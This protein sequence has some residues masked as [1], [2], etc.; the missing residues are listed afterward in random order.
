M[1]ATKQDPRTV[2][3]RAAAA[4]RERSPAT[5]DQWFGGIQFD[6]LTDGVLTLRAQNEFVMEWVKTNFVPE[7]TQQIERIAGWSIQ[8]NWVLDGN[9][10]DPVTQ[11]APTPPPVKPRP[12]TSGSSPQ[13]SDSP[14]M[15]GPTS[16][17]RPNS[18]PDDINP[19]H[20]F[21]NFV[22]GPS[23]QLAHAAAVAAA[24]GGGRRYNPLFLYGGTGLGKTHLVHAIARNSSMRWC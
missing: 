1:V 22:V 3:E 10:E 7:L 15:S 4:T 19:R 8:I 16:S 21:S 9:L 24:G 12:L 14:P 5:F 6:D 11:G 2:F 23:N 20:T 13:S 18:P 17:A